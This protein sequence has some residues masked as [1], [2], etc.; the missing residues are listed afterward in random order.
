[1]GDWLDNYRHSR[2]R[3]S[4][5]TVS[6][7]WW[8]PRK[9]ERWWGL[10]AYPATF[11]THHQTCS[12]SALLSGSRSAHFVGSSSSRTENSGV[13]MREWGYTR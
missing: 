8:D 4:D 6:D 3:R 1:M 2:L 5:R 9:L 13:M 7:V 11:E 10:P 12:R